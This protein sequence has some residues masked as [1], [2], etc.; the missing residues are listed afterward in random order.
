MKKEEVIY[1]FLLLIAVIGLVM[2][3]FG[4]YGLTD[5]EST[6]KRVCT[7]SDKCN[8]GDVCCFFY[9]ENKGICNKKEMCE[10]IMEISKNNQEFFSRLRNNE[11]KLLVNAQKDI[12]FGFLLIIVAVILIYFNKLS[13]SVKK[14][15]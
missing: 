9:E 6:F 10:D 11:R 1:F 2:V 8:I 4:Y 13:K 12:L 7:S 15:K 5:Q 14:K 3:G